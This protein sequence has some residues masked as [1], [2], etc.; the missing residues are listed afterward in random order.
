SAQMEMQRQPG[1]QQHATPVVG[2]EGGQ[3]GLGL[4]RADQPVLPGK[5]QQHRQHA[6]IRVEPQGKAAAHQQQAQ[7]GQPLQ[8]ADHQ[9]VG[10]AEQNG[11]GLDADQQIIRSAAPGVFGV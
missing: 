7:Q 4:A 11:G 6:Q 3:A 1:E 2:Q 9:P 5:A 10:L 8:Q